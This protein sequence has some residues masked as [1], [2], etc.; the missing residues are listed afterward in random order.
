[1]EAQNVCQGPCLISTERLWTLDLTSVQWSSVKLRGV[2]TVCPIVQVTKN[3]KQTQ[4]IHTQRLTNIQNQFKDAEGWAGPDPIPVR[5]LES[6]PS[7]RVVPQSSS[8]WSWH[9]CWSHSG[10]RLFSV[11]HEKLWLQTE[12]SKLHWHTETVS[13]KKSHLQVGLPDDTDET[14][15][16]KPTQQAHF[17]FRK[18]KTDTQNRDTSWYAH[19]P[20]GIPIPPSRFSGWGMVAIPSQCTKW[21]THSVRTPPCSDSGETTPQITHEKQSWFKLLEVY[22]GKTSALGT[23]RFPLGGRGVDYKLKG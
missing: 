17:H 13:D 10:S 21:K 7:L 6:F 18:Q 22:S 20:E 14:Q 4:E 3:T 11:S 16:N 2:V 12:I 15:I 5:L 19:I 9:V 23:T 1:L 8:Q